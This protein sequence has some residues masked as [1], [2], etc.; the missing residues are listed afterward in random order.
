MSAQRILV[1]KLGAL[2]D[3]VQA[4][5]P[6][7]AIR[8]RPV[9]PITDSTGNPDTGSVADGCQSSARSSGW[10]QITLATSRRGIESGL[11][12]GS[13]S[14]AIRSCSPSIPSRRPRR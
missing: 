12:R 4:M 1:I 2:G 3:F 13:A 10:S 8:S 6:F 7:A 5:G 9:P 14:T 11:P